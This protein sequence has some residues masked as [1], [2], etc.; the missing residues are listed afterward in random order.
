[1]NETG[2][3]DDPDRVRVAEGSDVETLTRSS[4][5]GTG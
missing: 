2:E 1:M 5:T 3:V 4:N